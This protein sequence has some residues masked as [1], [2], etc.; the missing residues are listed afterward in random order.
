MRVLGIDFGEKKIG[1]SLSEGLLAEPA[2]IV[3]SFKEVVR[4]CQEQEV[5][6]IVVG[7]S[8]GQ[9]AKRQ[10]RFGQ[11]LAEVT[12]LLVEFQD[13]TLTTQ[14]AIRKMKEGGKKVKG[15]KEDAF[16][17]SLILQEYLDRLDTETQKNSALPC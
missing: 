14:E 1:L 2:G 12:G 4:F 9:S 3:G 15:R 5:E 6:K 7:L 16:A 8:E 13:E 11:R 10:K 17:A